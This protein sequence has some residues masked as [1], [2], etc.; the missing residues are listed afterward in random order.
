MHVCT[1][2]FSGP[3]LLRYK[4]KRTIVQEEPIDEC[5]KIFA[6]SRP[7]FEQMTFD[8][9]TQNFEAVTLY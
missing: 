9:L 7:L 4:Q 3:S 2:Y 1:Q 6:I 8:A 5:I